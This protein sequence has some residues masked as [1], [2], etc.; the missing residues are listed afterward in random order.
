LVFTF[1]EMGVPRHGAKAQLCREEA[2]NAL[3]DMEEL[4]EKTLDEFRSRYDALARKALV[5]DWVALKRR[6]DVT[7]I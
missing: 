3:L 4:D 6:N 7:N 5:G 1:S 2:H